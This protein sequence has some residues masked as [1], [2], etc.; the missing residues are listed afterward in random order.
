MQRVRTLQKFNEVFQIGWGTYILRWFCMRFKTNEDF[1]NPK[2]QPQHTEALRTEKRRKKFKEIKKKRS[3]LLYFE[4]IEIHSTSQEL[5]LTYFSFRSVVQELL[6]VTEFYCSR[7]IHKM[8][9]WQSS[10]L[11]YNGNSHLSLVGTKQRKK[12][13]G[14]YSQ[15]QGSLVTTN[16]LSFSSA[17]CPAAQLIY[18]VYKCLYCN[19][20]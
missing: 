13:A 15:P 1:E 6:N 7:Y 11:V 18:S 2:H 3:N 19:L 5:Q 16:K 14:Q 17:M 9:T 4:T 12:S 8:E 20:L 10:C